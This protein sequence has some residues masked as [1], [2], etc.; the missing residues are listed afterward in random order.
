MLLVV[1]LEFNGSK[2]ADLGSPS[3]GYD[4]ISSIYESAGGHQGPGSAGESTVQCVKFE[5]IWILLNRYIL[6]WGS[7][8]Q[9]LEPE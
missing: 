4:I 3:T 1:S 8:H 5:M 7:C 2:A 6:N 9:D